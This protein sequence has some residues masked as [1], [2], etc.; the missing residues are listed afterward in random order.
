MFSDNDTSLSLQLTCADATSSCPKGY[1]STSLSS[2]TSSLPPTVTECTLLCQRCHNLCSSCDGP[3]TSDCLTCSYAN[4]TTPRTSCLESC[5]QT[6]ALDCVMC[7]EQCS[8]CTGPTDRDCVM[9]REDSIVDSQS[10]L[11]CVPQCQGNTFLSQES[12]AYRCQECDSECNG[13]RGSSNTDCTTCCNANFTNNS[14]SMCLAMYPSDYYEAKGTCLPCHEYCIRCTGPSSRNCTECVEDEVNG[15]CVPFC[16]IGMEYD[17]S[18]KQC[19][20]TRWVL[21]ST[22]FS[23]RNENLYIY[24]TT[25]I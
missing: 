19:V 20:L 21:V 14:V 15:E 2:I 11:V 5:E 18:E 13:C 24:Y 22:V 9:C 25:Y 17:T 1:F 8:G 23:P 16:P 4:S 10:R 6:S 7:H 3:T 12:G